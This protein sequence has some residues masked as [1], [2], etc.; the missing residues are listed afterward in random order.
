MMGRQL[1]PLS[2]LARRLLTEERQRSAED[3]ALKRRVLER[4]SEALASDR[5]SGVALRRAVPSG[6]GRRAPRAALLVAAAVAV[7]GLA[8][9]GAGMYGLSEPA[10]S[11]EGVVAPLVAPQ[12]PREKPIAPPLRAGITPEPQ[13]DTP[14]REAPHAAP[15]AKGAQAA[16]VQQYAVELG[17]LDPAR[18]SIARG[19]YAGAMGAIARH[20]RE[21]PRGQL[22][23]EREALRVRALWGMGQKASAESA[24][25]SFRQRYPRS[26]LLSWMKEPAR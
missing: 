19:D 20:Q 12:A 22:A 18:R 24:A 5:P 15:P 25:A 11:R 23:E 10:D 1:P 14:A 26:M 2:G 8:A 4:A 9:A 21:Y 17:V 13:A 6:P 3:E 7:A 16:S